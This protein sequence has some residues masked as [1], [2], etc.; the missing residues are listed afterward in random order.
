M[1]QKYSITFDDIK[2]SANTLAAKIYIA[3][4]S[5]A[6]TELVG[7]GEPIVHELLA[8]D[9]NKFDPIKGSA[10]TI[11]ILSTSV[12]QFL[13]DIILRSGKDIYCI[14]TKDAANYWIGYYSAED[15]G[16]DWMTYHTVSI[17]FV[18]MLGKLKDIEFSDEGIPY[19]GKKTIIQILHHC[20]SNTLSQLPLI[21][22]IN[23]YATSAHVDD[24]Y[25]DSILDQIYIDCEAFIDGDDPM[26]CY[27]VL[28]AILKIFG[29]RIWQQDYKWWIVPI[30]LIG[31]QFYY[32]QFAYGLTNYTYSSS[33]TTNNYTTIGNAT[34]AAASRNVFLN[35]SAFIE[36]DRAARKIELTQSYNIDDNIIPNGA[37]THFDENDEYPLG[38]WTFGSGHTFT[39]TTNIFTGGDILLKWQPEY[40]YNYINSIRT[41]GFKYYYK[42]DIGLKFKIRLLKIAT[43]NWYTKYS[44]RL[45]DGGSTNYY[46]QEDGT[47]E[48][49]SFTAKAPVHEFTAE[50]SFNI[51]KESTLEIESDIIPDSGTLY[52][53]LYGLYNPGM[54][55]I[56]TYLLE[57]SVEFIV[58]PTQSTKSI[59][60]EKIYSYEVNS[61]NS[62]V[63]EYDFILGDSPNIFLNET[64]M[65]R[66]CLMYHDGT[67]YV[68]TSEWHTQDNAENKGLLSL[69]LDHI[70]SVYNYNTW[71]L[72]G[73]LQGFLNPGILVKD[74]ADRWFIINDYVH[75]LKKGTFDVTLLQV[76]QA[77]AAYILHEDE[78]IVEF[79]DGDYV[80]IE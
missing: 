38:D 15:Y 35:H 65:Y 56:S 79:E 55:L 34:T 47:W 37:F 60:E 13:D 8:S 63:L 45:F 62:R 22:A 10:V 39:G 73:E 6:V 5:G 20:L 68:R 28:S 70:V 9:D 31:G 59:A 4:Y 32:R 17:T 23:I 36:I 19:W 42:D 1:A 30:K 21:E 48:S 69:L 18:D 72:S 61:D 14:L 46:L 66:N 24:G 58:Y 27:D 43:Q 41:E 26:N 71:K 49:G 67:D 7:T 12:N 51:Y 77:T 74:D 54:L 64:L 78:D 16:E 44:V 80:E 76:K 3:G 52:I 53:G 40:S 75:N 29:A 50:G 57:M 25:T 11:N 33:G 2:E